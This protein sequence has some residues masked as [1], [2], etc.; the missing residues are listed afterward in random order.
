MARRNAL[1]N[2]VRKDFWQ[3]SNHLIYSPRAWP[4]G[5]PICGRLRPS[6]E[7]FS[8][9]FMPCDLSHRLETAVLDPTLKRFFCCQMTVDQ[10]ACLLQ[11]AISLVAIIVAPHAHRPQIQI[12]N[13]HQQRWLAFNPELIQTTFIP[14]SIQRRILSRSMA[15]KPM[16]IRLQVFVIRLKHS[17][18]DLA[19]RLHIDP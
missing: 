9:F 11:R 10:L 19:T 7:S 16:P 12:G 17:I 1:A 4:T 2:D 6:C 18:F 14:L 13:R 5:S 15:I 3:Q 8:V